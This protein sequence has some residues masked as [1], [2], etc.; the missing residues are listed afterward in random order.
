MT[1]TI[2]TT[3][4]HHD[5]PRSTPAMWTPVA[6]TSVGGS[7]KS[8]P[9][10]RAQVPTVKAVPPSV[11]GGSTRSWRAQGV[12]PHPAPAGIAG[13][14][15]S[16]LAAIPELQTLRILPLYHS[17][18]RIQGDRRQKGQGPKLKPADK[19]QD[20]I[21]TRA[22]SCTGPPN[23]HTKVTD[24]MLPVFRPKVRD[25][26]LADFQLEILRLLRWIRSR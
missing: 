5:E 7:Y 11:I 8:S 6:K 3:T 2:T 9:C 4:R 22:E 13:T 20:M 26:T 12:L 25:G 17:I 1:T 18:T 15:T 14:H 23:V 24:G 21:S 10:Q 16:R 19:I